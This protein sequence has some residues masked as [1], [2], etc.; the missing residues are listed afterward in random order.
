MVK[1]KKKIVT[2]LAKQKHIIVI[3]F[4]NCC[5]WLAERLLVENVLFFM[6]LKSRHQIEREF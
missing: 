6:L 5:K 3:N 4:E 2:E 1:I